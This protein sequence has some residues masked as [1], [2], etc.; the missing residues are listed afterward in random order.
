MEKDNY[1]GTYKIIDQ[2]NPKVVHS[3]HEVTSKRE[4]Q[5]LLDRVFKY[6]TDLF[7]GNPSQTPKRQLIKI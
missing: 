7:N 2:G 5:T 3:T 6:N 4:F 1:A